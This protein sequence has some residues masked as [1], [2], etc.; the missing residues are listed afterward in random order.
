MNGSKV[1]KSVF[2]VSVFI[3]IALGVFATHM[4]QQVSVDSL[5]LSSDTLAEIKS[6]LDNE[7]LILREENAKL[8]EELLACEERL[9]AVFSTRVTV[10]CYNS[11]RAQT[12]STPFITA[13][14]WKVRPGII[15]VSTD[16]LEKGYTPGSK[17]YL[18]NFGV[19]TVGDIM[20]DRFTKR[21]DIWL[22]KG[23]RVF[24]QTG[25]LMVPVTEQA[26]GTCQ[27]CA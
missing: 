2:I 21:V 26:K 20:N 4:N 27:E 19:F 5:Q 3:F 9:A 15:A 18:K 10:T 13:F 17:V 7:N 22:P 23:K 14:N 12:D 11:E 1:V 8:K 25:V 6:D 24:K 16:L